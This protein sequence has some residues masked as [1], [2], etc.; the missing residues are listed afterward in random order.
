M[1]QEQP[2]EDDGRSM[3]SSAPDE[4]FPLPDRAN[5][6]SHSTVPRANVAQTGDGLSQRAPRAPSEMELQSRVSAALN[7]VPALALPDESQQLDQSPPGPTDA[8]RWED[9]EWA[10][11]RR[12]LD[13]LAVL[14][15]ALAGV[16]LRAEPDGSVA[17]L[18]RGQDQPHAVPG[19]QGS[20]L[21]RLCEGSRRQL[22]I[23]RAGAEFPWLLEMMARA[24][25]V[26]GGLIVAPVPVT[27]GSP[28]GVVLGVGAETT[29]FDSLAPA[30]AAVSAACGAGCQAIRLQRRIA[31]EAYARDAFISF[32]A[33][34]LRS[35]VTSTKGYA[36]LLVRQARKH[37]LPETMAHSIRAIEEQSGRMGDLVGELLDA[38]R[39]RRG[40]LDVLN[41]E[42]DV[43]P[44]I[45]KL[46]ERVCARS[47]T[48]QIELDLRVPSLVGN[49]DPQRVEQIVRDLLD[50]A[51]RFSPE[52]NRVLVTVE[53]ERDMA[54]ITVRDEGIGVAPQERERVF[55]YLYRAPGAQRHNLGGLGIGLY[56][57]RFLA[58]RMG[59]RLDLLETRTTSPSGSIFRLTLPL[60][61]A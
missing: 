51:V 29:S 50:N 43:V 11:L 27:A 48:Y 39:I 25:N 36:Q 37:P 26:S 53:R 3:F 30:I 45:E 7:M 10:V 55:D 42:V 22:S 31:D 13:A 18:S 54:Q 17:G 38:S 58:E 28:L 16:A 59:G 19:A 41:Q 23:D 44:L 40:A 47:E 61:S 57:S 8:A 15:G 4:S 34:E 32:A 60:G 35:P 46:V 21:A 9:A 14:T 5:D 6:P 33:H 2:R 20:A 1:C 56:V 52:S 24:G 49:W 12:G